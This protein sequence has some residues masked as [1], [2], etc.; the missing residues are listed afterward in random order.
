MKALHE[1]YKATGFDRTKLY[2]G[3]AN[4]KTQRRSSIHEIS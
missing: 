4:W 3:T 1:F 2:G